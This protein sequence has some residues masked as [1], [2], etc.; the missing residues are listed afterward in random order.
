[1]RLHAGHAS[2]TT[3]LLGEEP[4]LLSAAIFHRDPDLHAHFHQSTGEVA[5]GGSAQGA[6]REAI[7]CGT[8]RSVGITDGHAL[9][10]VGFD[11][12]LDN[13]PSGTREQAPHP[14]KLANLLEFGFGR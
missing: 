6:C 3:L 4:A 2:L 9:L 13:L 10:V 7:A 8:A 1:M 5:S 12:Y 11:G 14:C